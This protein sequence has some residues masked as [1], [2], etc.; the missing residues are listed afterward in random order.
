ML[1]DLDITHDLQLKDGKNTTSVTTGE[2]EF[3]DRSTEIA[4]N[5]AN[6]FHTKA[7]N[8]F[9]M[10]TFLL[11]VNSLLHCFCLVLGT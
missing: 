4:L 6:P 8:E 11:T 1:E 9:K 10:A 2:Q 3:L 5:E 7:S